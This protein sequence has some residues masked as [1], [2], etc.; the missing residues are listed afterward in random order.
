M[1]AVFFWNPTKSTR[2]AACEIQMS[3]PLSRRELRKRL[4]FKL[5]SGSVLRAVAPVDRKARNKFA[6]TML[7][8]LDENNEFLRNVI[9]SDTSAFQVSVGVNNLKV[10]IYE[11]ENTDATLDYIRD[12]P[13]FTVWRGLMDRH[14]IRRFF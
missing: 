8:Y 13:K 14:L 11:L 7:G 2:V 9:S 1:C 12:S 6:R 5:K 4:H 10:R 3:R